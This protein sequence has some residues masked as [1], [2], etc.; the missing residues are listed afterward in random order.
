MWGVRSGYHCRTRVDRD[1]LGKVVACLGSA[2]AFGVVHRDLFRT[3]GK[4]MLVFKWKN[5]LGELSTSRVIVWGMTEGGALLP[6]T[7]LY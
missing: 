1:C 5:M 2:G 4:G 3:L 7:P 6:V